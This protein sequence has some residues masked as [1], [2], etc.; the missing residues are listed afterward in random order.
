M[1]T[2][3]YK[4]LKGNHGRIEP[5]RG[6][7]IYGPAPLVDV[8]ELTD[9]QANS[10]VFKG[11]VAHIGQSLTLDSSNYSVT[12]SPDDENPLAVIQTLKVSDAEEFIDSLDSADDLEQL[13]GFEAASQNRKSVMKL[14]D[15][16]MNQI[17][18]EEK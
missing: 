18:N 17:Q 15:A 11:R 16:K 2:Y 12:D 8:I 3:P 6:L 13:K 14:I 10:S 5:G 4:M 9:E 1:K 7:V